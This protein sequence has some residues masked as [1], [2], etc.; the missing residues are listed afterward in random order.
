MPV[1]HNLGAF[2]LAVSMVFQLYSPSLLLHAPLCN[3]HTPYVSLYVPTQAAFWLVVFMAYSMVFQFRTHSTCPLH[4]L[5][6]FLLIDLMAFQF[7]RP[8]LFPPSHP[9]CTHLYHSTP[10]MVFLFCS[11]APCLPNLHLV[12]HPSDIFWY[13]AIYPLPTCK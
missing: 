9:L 7:H 3:P 13:T 12:L 11:K 5:E 6:A 8:H 2:S 1:L 10:S 4:T